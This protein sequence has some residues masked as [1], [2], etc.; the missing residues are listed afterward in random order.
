MDNPLTGLEVAALG[1]LGQHDGRYVSSSVVAA[2]LNKRVLTDGV[3]NALV[4][5][6]VRGLAEQHPRAP[7]KFRLTQYGEKWL[8]ES[9][10]SQAIVPDAGWGARR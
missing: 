9:E 10:A 3:V 4:R 8:E 5:L 2:E 6:D 1:V 7:W